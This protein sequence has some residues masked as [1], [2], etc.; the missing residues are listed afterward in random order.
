MM[1]TDLKI[2]YED[3]HIIVVIKD[4]NILSQ[5]DITN[6]LDI[7]TIIKGYIKEKYHKPNDVFLGL[8]HRLDRRVSGVMV[9]AKTSKA[10]SRLSEAIRNKDFHKEYL[11]ICQ[12]KTKPSDR[13]VNYMEKVQTKEGNRAQIVDKDTK[14]AKE[15]ILEYR[16]IRHLKIDNHDFSLI[17]IHLITG[18]YNQI[19]KQLSF[20]N[21]PIINDFKYDYQ[22]PN[23][24]DEL[25]LICAKISFTH[26][27][28]KEFLE[29]EYC[30]NVGIWSF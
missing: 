19:R 22:G 13:L 8:I 9:F 4:I 3:N 27:T 18:R 7:M 29:F 12:G 5:K 10:A 21:H 25:G 11:A 20:N 16:T 17:R 14:N 2:L 6:D 26:P 28:T 30:P 24:F 23:Y 1:K 15:A